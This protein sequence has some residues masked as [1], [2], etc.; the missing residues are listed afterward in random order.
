MQSSLR[1]VSAML[2]SRP[3]AEDRPN[4]DN[5]ADV[6][7]S[8]GNYLVRLWACVGWGSLSA[9]CLVAPAVR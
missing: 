8:S 7:L 4:R 5:D 1:H 9:C 2:L 6:L 3:L